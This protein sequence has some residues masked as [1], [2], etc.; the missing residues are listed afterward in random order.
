M[1]TA[2]SSASAPTPLA[3]PESGWP[4]F[5]RLLTFWKPFQRQVIASA[6]LALVMVGFGLLVPTFTGRAIDHFRHE[7][8]D[9]IN[10]DA[11]LILAAALGSALLNASRRIVA[12]TMS[13]G[14]EQMLREQLFGHLSG[15]GFRFFDRQ[16]TGQLLSRV[17]SDVNQVRFFLGYGLTYLFVHG[18]KLVTIPIVLWF[19][20]PSLAIVVYITAPLIFFSS[21]TY[22]RRSHPVLRES[23]QKLSLV[24][25]HGE[26]TIV[27]ARVVRAFGQEARE[28][29]HFRSLTQG[30]VEQERRAMFIEAKFR[31]LYDLIPSLCL[32]VLVLVGGLAIDRGTMS[33]GDFFAF[34]TLVLLLTGPLRIIGNLLG[35]AQRA[36]ASSSRLWEILD[37]DDRIPEPEQPAPMPTQLD[38]GTEL[39]FEHVSFGYRTDE[40]GTTRRVLDDVTLTIPA[41]R[42]V[43][44]I[45]PTGCGKTTL[46]SLIPRFYDPEH[47]GTVRMD[48]VDLRELDLQELRESIGIVDQEPF[49]FSASIRQNL[50]YGNPGADDD[51]LWAAL[52]AAQAREF[53]ERLPDGFD[54]VVGERGLTLSGGQRQRLAIARALVVD[55]RVLILDDATASVDSQVEARISHALANAARKRTT[56]VIAHRPSTIALADHI[57][58]LREGRVEDQGTHE[59]LLERSETYRMVHEQRGVRREFL[60]DPSEERARRTADQDGAPA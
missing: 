2:F 30:V 37:S 4:A 5:R 18:I 10:V 15:L 25:A 7:Q 11:L 22:S 8:Y 53:V 35:R 55:P 58:V 42:T 17:T 47:G 44:L 54:T 46:A 28:I 51:A 1:S 59:Y 19:Y 39:S 9:K 57:V 23:Q 48:G 50:A 27:G 21:V 24:T 33:F 20:E 6:L 60:L 26:E 31:P 16:Q 13:L 38:E 49:L 36:T 12:G 52:D 34:Y 43:A 32:M 56:I 14:M 45:G 40:D 3:P 41:G 29:E